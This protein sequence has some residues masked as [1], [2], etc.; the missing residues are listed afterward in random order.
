MSKI[1]KFIMSFFAKDVDKI[2]RPLTKILNELEEHVSAQVVS[3][4]EKAKAIAAAEVAHT[5]VC[6]EIAKAEA[7]LRKFSELLK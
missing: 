2:L 6:E 5:C 4:G 1:L 3:Q 7:A